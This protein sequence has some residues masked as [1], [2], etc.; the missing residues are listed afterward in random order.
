M[1]TTTRPKWYDEKLVAYAG[2]IARLARVFGGS[3]HEE[4][5]Q[6][7]CLDAINRWDRYVPDQY[8]FAMWLKLCARNVAS[9]RKQY[10]MAQMRH[11]DV[12]AFDESYTMSAQPSQHEAME[13]ADTVRHL[14]GRNG[15]IL[16]RVAAGEFM[17][18]IGEEL[19]VS[20]QRV[21]Q[22]VRQERA[23]LRKRMGVRPAAERMVAA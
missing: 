14:T 21:E 3:H 4:V 22:I 9:K 20:K 6:E 8:S 1:T 5:A 10:R 12:C 18:D 17:H 16:L 13:L 7:I 19:G 2:R 15:Q 23:M 11:A